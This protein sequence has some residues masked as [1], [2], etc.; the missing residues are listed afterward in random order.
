MSEPGLTPMERVVLSTLVQNID[1][2]FYCHVDMTTLARLASVNVGTFR[3][4][5]RELMNRHYVQRQTKDSRSYMPWPYCM[6]DYRSPRISVSDYRYVRTLCRAEEDRLTTI[7]TN[8]DPKRD[9][10]Q[11]KMTLQQI[12]RIRDIGDLIEKYVSKVEA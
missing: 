6:Q 4:T 10:E 2:H 1:V 8:L 7:A 11:Y 9:R 12:D 3:E 5:M